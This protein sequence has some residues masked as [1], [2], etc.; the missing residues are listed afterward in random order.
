MDAPTAVINPETK[1][2][3]LARAAKLP[4]NPDRA[5]AFPLGS[6]T[7]RALMID[8]DDNVLDQFELAHPANVYTDITHAMAGALVRFG[9]RPVAG[10]A[11]LAGMV[12]GSGLLKF[13]NVPDWPEFDRNDSKRYFGFSTEWLNDGMAGYFGLRRLHPQDFTTLH[14]GQ[15]QPGDPYIYAIFG[16]GL[17]VGCEVSREDGHI[18]FVP[19][20]EED[21]ELQSWLRQHLGHWPEWEDVT[22]GVNGF[23]NV[24]DFYLHHHRVGPG[25][26][27][28]REFEAS[29]RGRRGEVVTRF[30]LLGHPSA[31][32]AAKMA[33]EYLGGWLGAM[34][35]SHQVRRIDVSPGILSDPAMRQFCLEET[36]FLAS[37]QEQG[38][39]MFQK[40]AA[41]CT[42]RV[43]LRNPEHE[44]AVERAA[45]LL[46][47]AR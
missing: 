32:A 39:P 46:R 16:T 5:V 22:S 11:F 2:L 38:R 23:G 42:V 15:S 45:E 3:L 33:F 24:A 41:D 47:A 34:A 10:A 20:G 36:G 9:C 14:E 1:D 43:C 12:P 44:G 37:F 19:R 6:S 27:F 26:D 4:R 7:F 29:P 8:R 35:I 13:T 25:D 28:R 40:F 30:A 18:L 17:N 21:N 31:R